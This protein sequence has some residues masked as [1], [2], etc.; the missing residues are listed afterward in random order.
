MRVYDYIGMYWVYY[1]D[2][3]CFN[4]SVN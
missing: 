1:V 4:K 2:D 3:N